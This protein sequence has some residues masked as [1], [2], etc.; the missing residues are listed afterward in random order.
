MAIFRKIERRLENLVEGFFTHRF[1]SALQPVELARKLAGE[2]DDKRQVSVAH[3]YV[4][5]VFM[6]H[7]APDDFEELG[8]V[9]QALAAEL[10]EY[11][12]THAQENEYRFSGAIHLSIAPE[13]EL[14]RGECDIHSHFEEID[15]AA[16]ANDTQIISA[17]ELKEALV[18]K[19]NGRLTETESGRIFEIAPGTT[20]GRR[21]DNDVVLADNGV[22]RY[23]ARIDADQEG[24]LLVDLDSTNGTSVN[25][26][27]VGR[28]KLI[29]GD[30]IKIGPIE[31][32]F[33]QTEL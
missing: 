1:S 19:P 18:I 4:P 5:N 13:P 31:L 28:A 6:I 3:T 21:S 26:E 15:V 20:I 23:H 32:S 14:H 33:D 8:G 24:L 12:K 9:Q 30:T 11:I 27:E 2:M 29:D 16:S 17:E 7:L 10:T 25:S 22:S